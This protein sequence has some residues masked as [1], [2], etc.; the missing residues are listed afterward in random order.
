LIP[1]FFQ[2]AAQSFFLVPLSRHELSKFFSRLLFNL[3]LGAVLLIASNLKRLVW[4]VV[5]LI[6][7]S[8][9]ESVM[10]SFGDG[11]VVLCYCFF[12]TESFTQHQCHHCT[13]TNATFC[14]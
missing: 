8:V 7:K 6:A 14:S 10:E 4:L 12:T 9:V 2:I 11:I 5:K 3:F 1:S 13:Y